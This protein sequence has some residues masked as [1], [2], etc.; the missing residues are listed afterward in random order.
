MTEGDYLTVDVT[1][2]GTTAPGEDL[3]V[4]IKYKETT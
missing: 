4:Q 1:S 3:V 2:I